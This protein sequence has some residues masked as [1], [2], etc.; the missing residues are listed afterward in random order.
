MRVT[1]SGHSRVGQCSKALHLRHLL[2]TLV[3]LHVL[4]QLAVIGNTLGQ[5]T[6]GPARI[7]FV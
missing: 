5:H 1:V 6:I 7:G 4:T 3:R 2:Q